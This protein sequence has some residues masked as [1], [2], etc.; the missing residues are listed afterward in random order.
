MALPLILTI[1]VVE[2]I[3]LYLFSRRISKSIYAIIYLLTRS[4]RVA[5]GLLTTILLP[6]TVIHE[7]AHLLTAEILRVPTGK[8]SFEPEQQGDSIRAGSVTIARTDPFRRYLIGFA[9]II[10]GLATLA[11]LIYLS[12][13]YIPPVVELKLRLV[14]WWGAAYLLFAVSN[15][16]FSSRK[17]MEGFAV[18]AP[19]LILLVAIPYFLGF[20]ITLTPWLIENVSMI[21][22]KLA[23][24]LGYVLGINTAIL[25][26]A[27]GIL[28]LW[29]KVFKEEI[30][31]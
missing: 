12:F 30:K 14:L 2:L 9:P 18:F 22:E 7:F 4:K 1:L 24:I 17:D 23:L 20:R 6:G 5:A 13:T 29:K 27:M 16:M 11:I 3:L 25:L 19:V 21:I 28:R 31:L 10:W 8:L 26:V 15:S